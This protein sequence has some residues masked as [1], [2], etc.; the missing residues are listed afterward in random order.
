LDPITK[1]LNKIDEMKFESIT[2]FGWDQKDTFVKVYI[3]SGLDGIGKI[4]K[5]NITFEVE[6]DNLDL[7]V[8]NLNNKN[9]RLR[10]PEL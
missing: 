8:Q 6:D 7:K 3:T 5:E 1:A 2:K 9:Y 10:I 4:P